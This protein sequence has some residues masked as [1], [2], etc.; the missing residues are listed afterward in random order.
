MEGDGKWKLVG[1]SFRDDEYRRFLRI[2]TKINSPLIGAVSRRISFLNRWAI[3]VMET[4]Q[5][6]VFLLNGNFM[7]RL[8]VF[9]KA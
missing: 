7:A 5:P 4:I 9:L 2:K 1:G 6:P 3:M 8:K